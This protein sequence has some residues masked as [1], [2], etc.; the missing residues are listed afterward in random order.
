M[1]KRVFLA[2]MLITSAACESPGATDQNA[3]DSERSVASDEG[4][5]ETRIEDD[6]SSQALDKETDMPERDP[7][8]AMRPQDG[9]IRPGGPV[10]RP[11]PG[12]AGETWSWLNAEDI[13]GAWQLRTETTALGCRLI[14]GPINAAG[15]GTVTFEGACPFTEAELRRWRHDDRLGQ[16]FLLDSDGKIAVRLMQAGPKRFRAYQ[17]D[18]WIYFDPEGV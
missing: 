18:G 4:L 2:S 6:V 7:D 15:S 1:M 5:S 11:V 10:S 13:A 16:V 8:T 9:L 14:L 3:V 12:S 17:P